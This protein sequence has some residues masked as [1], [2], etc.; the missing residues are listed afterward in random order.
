MNI[1]IGLV[2]DHQLFLK[3][4]SSLLSSISGF[5]IVV[6]ANHG[7]DLQQKIEKGAPLPDII[8]IDVEMP[9]MNG[10]DTARWLR[11]HHPSVRLVALSMKDNEQTVLDMIKAGC[12]SY[13]LKDTHPDELER[14]LHEVYYK[15][16][17]NSDINKV[18]LAG[19]LMNNQSAMIL[20][21]SENERAF[22]QHA[23]SDLTYKQV[24][25][26]M[27][28]SERTID[29]YRESLFSKFKVQSRTGMVLEGIRR[30][31]VRV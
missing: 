31:L 20:T 29:G 5:A 23:S 24:A 26:L 2:D 8:L 10:V 19:L 15:N 4:L 9:V 21:I 6:E 11:A 18:D 1:K 16:Y 7:K 22:L 28:L 13:L 30:G 12:C 17:Y 25:A 3:S 14:A 27:Q